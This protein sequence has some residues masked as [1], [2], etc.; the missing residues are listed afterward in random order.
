M[1][2]CSDSTIVPARAATHEQVI[3]E[4]LE[5]LYRLIL[6]EGCSRTT[7]HESVS[8]LEWATAFVG[9]DAVLSE[10]LKHVAGVFSL[11]ACFS[12]AS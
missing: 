5:S 11:L 4:W 8:A 1:L 12:S 9:D 7:L 2:S 6:D 3:Y 10:Q